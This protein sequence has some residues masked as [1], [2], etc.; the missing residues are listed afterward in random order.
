MGQNIILIFTTVTH[1][2]FIS[3]ETSK[4]TI[5]GIV[6]QI[7]RWTVFLENE[8]EN[9]LF[10]E[11]RY[12]SRNV[13]RHFPAERPWAGFLGKMK[14]NWS[15]ACRIFRTTTDF[16]FQILN[17]TTFPLHFSNI[18]YFIKFISPFWKNWWML[19][20]QL[21][22]P[23]IVKLLTLFRGYILIFPEFFRL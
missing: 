10:K 3:I 12:R 2:M 22:F 19:C 1:V 16:M 23:V 7:L 15:S 4:H 8:R 17:H 13:Q 11:A 5:Y 6:L 18:F 9:L 14:N 20:T 21:Y